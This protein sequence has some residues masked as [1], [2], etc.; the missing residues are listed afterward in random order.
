M[1]EPDL[2]QAQPLSDKPEEST[3]SMAPVNPEPIPDGRKIGTPFDATENMP[4]ETTPPAVPPTA[5]ENPVVVSNSNS[6]SKSNMLLMAGVLALIIVI[7]VLGWSIYKQISNNKS[8]TAVPVATPSI[9]AG[10]TNVPTAMP[11]IAPTEVPDEIEKSLLN[12]GTSNDITSIE[13]D[14]NGTDFTQLEAT[15]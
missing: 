3:P 9:A 8:T 2:N 15:E 14:L 1:I 11:S 5:L 12:V 7:G 10:A 13:K 4:V 6:S